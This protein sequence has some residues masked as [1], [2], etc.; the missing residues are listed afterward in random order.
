MGDEA[1]AQGEAPKAPPWKAEKSVAQWGEVVLFEGCVMTRRM[2]GSRYTTRFILDKYGFDYHM[3]DNEACCGAL[4][5][6]VG[7]RAHGAG[8]L[9]AA[10]AR[11]APTRSQAG[12][13]GPR[14]GASAHGP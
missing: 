6:P 7:I 3:L 4:G 5:A 12:R 1:A 9:G 8:S 2:V 14:R 13:A 11:T 10:P